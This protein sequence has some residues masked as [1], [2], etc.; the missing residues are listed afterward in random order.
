MS[1]FGFFHHRYLP[2]NR[3]CRNH[4][5]PFPMCVISACK[6]KKSSQTANVYYN[7]Q[8]PVLQGF[9]LKTYIIN[10]LFTICRLAEASPAPFSRLFRRVGWRATAFFA[11]IDQNGIFPKTADRAPRNINIV[12]FYET[13]K[14]AR[15]ADDERSHAGVCTVKLKIRSIA[16]PCPVIQI[17]DFELS[18][19]FG[20]T[21]VQSNAPSPRS[22]FSV[23]AKD[24]GERSQRQVTIIFSPSASTFAWVIL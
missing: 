18:Q 10:S 5:S 2:R 14:S 17:D 15:A 3:T 22:L 23:Y 16:E 20:S 8:V 6:E 24:R 21:K 13:E 11:Q 19:L 4:H 1:S 12:G 9:F 7:T